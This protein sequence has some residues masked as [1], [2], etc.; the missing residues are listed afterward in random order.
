MNILTTRTLRYTDEGV[1]AEKD[2]VLTI[3]EPF[4]N[5]HGDWV[6]V[7]DFEPPIKPRLARARGVDVLQAFVDGL[8][9]ARL[10]FETTKWS[11]T[12][13]WQ[14]LRDCGLPMN[15]GPWPV[16]PPEIP[17]PED[18]PGT[19]EVF[20]TR[21]LRYPDETG[22]ATA[23]LLT[24]F[25]PYQA[26]LGAW[27]CA[28]AFGPSET[29]PLR[30]GMGADFIEAALDGLALARATYESMLPKGWAPPESEDL[31]LACDDLPYKIGRSFWTGRPKP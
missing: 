16:Q 29:A 6:C 10:Y 12:G 21:R 13:H 8:L 26:E 17:P 2:V 31:L 1:E 14:G 11:R 25:K 15:K 27:K 22:A 4:E 28:F 3:F 30:H 5:D 23:L 19:L 24:V 18:N 9:D 7:F 20:A